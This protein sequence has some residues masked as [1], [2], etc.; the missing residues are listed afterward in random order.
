MAPIL[1]SWSRN[2]AARRKIGRMFMDMLYDAV[3]FIKE[4]KFWAAAIVPFVVGIIVL[5][6]L[7]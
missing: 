4:H 6:A 7:R 1:L 5:R 3:E 2:A